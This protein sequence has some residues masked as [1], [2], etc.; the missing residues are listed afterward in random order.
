MVV[1][2][3]R[4]SYPLEY[5]F[6]NTLT[7]LLESLGNGKK[8]SWARVTSSLFVSYSSKSSSRNTFDM[9]SSISHRARLVDVSKS[10]KNSEGNSVP[11][12]NTLHSNA[13]S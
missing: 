10:L 5:H 2:E 13:L 3:S 9:A 7:P 4:I 11:R 12:Q 1:A 6:T 8:S